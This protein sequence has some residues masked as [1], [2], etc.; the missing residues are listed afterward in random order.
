MQ[1]LLLAS[2]NEGKLRELRAL[3]K[4][5]QLDLLDPESLKLKLHVEESGDDY[6]SNARLKAIAFAEASGIWCLAD[7]SGLEVDALGGA[8]GLHSARLIGPGGSDEA[9]RARLLA[10]LSAHPRPWTAKFRSVVA[11]ANPEGEIDLAEGECPG[12]IIHEERGDGGFGY[13]PIFLLKGVGR[14]MAEL[15][16]EEKNRLSH[17]AHATGALLPV[18]RSRLGLDP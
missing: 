2:N 4:G 11:L 16:M 18:L 5:L 10:L 14:T 1:K 12:E 3:L 7:D 8:P 15:G 13:D 9:R 6:A 17:R